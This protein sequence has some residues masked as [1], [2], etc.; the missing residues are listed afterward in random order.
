VLRVYS[1]GHQSRGVG[2]MEVDRTTHSVALGLNTTHSLGLVVGFDGT[3]SY[4]QPGCACHHIDDC[5]VGA[6]AR[7][8]SPL[9]LEGV[10]EVS[11]GFLSPPI[12]HGY[13]HVCDSPDFGQ[14]LCKRRPSP[15]PHVTS[16]GAT[17]CLKSCC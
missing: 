11:R 10:S 1:F 4:Y 2:E 8:L 9:R 12:G 17:L 5:R 3:G 7:Q 6:S 14:V 15:L 13:C 16:A